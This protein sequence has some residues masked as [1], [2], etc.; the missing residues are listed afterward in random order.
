L[1]DIRSDS[2]VNRYLGRQAPNSIK[3]LDEFVIARNQDAVDN[4]SLTWAMTTKESDALIGSIC[5]WNFSED[6][7]TGEL[8]Y[9][10]SPAHQKRGYMGEALARVIAYGQK[11]LGL[12][13]MVAYTREDNLA[14]RNLLEKHGFGLKKYL[15]EVGEERSQAVYS[16]ST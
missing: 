3:V 9:E 8:G 12:S 10:L 15:L 6:G 14:S 2:Q 11:D 4:K 7:L 13:H 1:Y 16:C 5:I